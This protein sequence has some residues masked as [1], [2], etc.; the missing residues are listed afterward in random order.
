MTIEPVYQ[1]AL[2]SAA[3][4]ADW[5]IGDNPD[6]ILSEKGFTNSQ[7][8]QFKSDYTVETFDKSDNGFAAVVFTN[9][10]TRKKT[11]SFRG[12]E[13]TDLGDIVN[14]VLLALGVQSLADFFGFGQNDSIESFLVAA[15]LV[16]TAGNSLVAANSVDFVDKRQSRLPPTFPFPRRTSGD[17][18]SLQ[19]FWFG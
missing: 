9:K 2:L 3:A 4:Y 19:V 11:V 7:I 1:E 13:P 5:G 16:D 15:G 17:C 10:F 14:D 8:I 12:T 6:T 18:R